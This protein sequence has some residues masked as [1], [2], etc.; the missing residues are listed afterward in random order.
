MLLHRRQLASIAG[1]QNM[2]RE[3]LRIGFRVRGGGGDRMPYTPGDGLRVALFE[4]LH[5][6]LGTKRAIEIAN[7][8]DDADFERIGLDGAPGGPFLLVER[9][10]YVGAAAKSR[11]VKGPYQDFDQA[12]PRL[13]ARHAAKQPADQIATTTLIIDLGALSAI[14]RQRIEGLEGP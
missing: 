4:A 1:G 8:V 14:A 10:Q 3:I 5:P 9:A 11:L 6:D 7:L 2:I 13:K 12:L